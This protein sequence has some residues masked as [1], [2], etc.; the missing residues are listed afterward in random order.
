MF[1]IFFT[2]PN[3]NK[4]LY[5]KNRNIYLNITKLI[6]DFYP[7]FNFVKIWSDFVNNSGTHYDPTLGQ[8]IKGVKF[9]SEIF[10]KK[11]ELRLPVSGIE[12]KLDSCY[13]SF[14]KLLL[15]ILLK[16]VSYPFFSI[17]PKSFIIFIV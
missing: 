4:F 7:G 5:N 17:E 12:I 3:S 1:Q 10:Y 16:S 9:T 8:Y 6:F 11:L 15:N 13:N 14:I 2:N